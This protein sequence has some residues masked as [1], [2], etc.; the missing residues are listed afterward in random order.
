MQILVVL[1]PMAKSAIIIGGGIGGLAT[2]CIL[3]KAGYKV[4]VLEKNEQLGGRAGQLKAQGYTFDTGPSWY[5]MPD[6]FQHF[7]EL[8]GEDINDHLSLKRLNP[9]YRVYYKDRGQHIDIAGDTSI[10][11]KTFETI[12]PGG[13][14]QFDAYINRAEYIYD[15]AMSK[16]LYKNYDSL[17]DFVRGDI[18]VQ[19]GRLRLFSKMDSYVRGFFKDVRLQQIMQYPLVFL[20]SSPYNAPAIYSLLSHVDFNQGVY[21]PMGGMYE[22]VKALVRVG[23]KYGVTYEVDSPVEQIIVKGGAAVGVRTKDKEMHADLV[24][25]DADVHHTETKLLDKKYR[26]HSEHYWSKRIMAPSALLMYLGVDRQYDSLRHHNLLF[27][28][29][30]QKNFT[31]LFDE[32]VLPDDP[33]LYV[34]APGKTDPSVAPKGHE[35]IFVLVPLAAGLHVSPKELDKYGEAILQTMEQEMNLPGLRRHIAYKKSFGIDD[36]ATRFNSY[37]GTGLGLSHTLQQTALFRPSNRSRKVKGLYYVGANV[38][39]GIGV[40]ITLISAELLYKR[41]INDSTAKPL[42]SL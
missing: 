42:A 23:N 41:L 9:S 7:F 12:E 28:K 39:P 10:D 16:L 17:T 5:L 33:S 11:R 6:V 21:Y 3:G 25:S 26:D 19:A 30:W 34:C 27:S 24:I 8:L 2:A 18:A 29:D 32:P 4:T 31:Q 13:A 36:F 40:P 22:L 38:H 20:G 14:K 35:N 15:T 1:E 37:K